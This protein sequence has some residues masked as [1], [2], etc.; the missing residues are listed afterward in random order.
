MDVE[1]FKWD[2]DN[3]NVSWSFNGKPIIK[4]FHNAYFASINNQRQYVIVEAGQ[5]YSQD[6]IYY[7]SFDGSTLFAMDKSNGKISW[8]LK[9]QH[10]E[11][12]CKVI[13]HAQIYFEQNLVIILSSEKQNEKVLKGFSL[14]GTPLFVN[15]P[16]QG[17]DF[18]Y[19]SIFNN[20]PSVVCDGDKAHTDAY[21]RNRWHFI[22]NNQTGEMTRGNLAY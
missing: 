19:L 13:L 15:Q 11:L 12:N 4:T 7:I 9:D 22:I 5:N 3:Q 20:Q 16:P 6:Q 14:D 1:N 2:S 21:N 10:V 18:N 17:F 8:Q